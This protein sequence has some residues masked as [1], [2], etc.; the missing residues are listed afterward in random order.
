MLHPLHLLTDFNPRPPRGGRPALRRRSRYLNSYFNPRPPRGGRHFALNVG[1]ITGEFQST[2]S[3]RRT[4]VAL[5][6]YL[7]NTNISIHVLRE[8][9]DI[10]PCPLWQASCRFQST[11]S[12]RRTTLF[13]GWQ[14]IWRS[15]SIHVLR[16]EDD[17]SYF[18]FFLSPFLFQSTSSAR[19]TT[20][21]RL[22]FSI[23]QHYFNPCPPR[24]GRQPPH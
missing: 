17:D 24:G 10:L 3:A 5:Q 4:T 9:D 16:E 15:I 18:H 12:A 23:L 13:R 6:R 1:K 2:S 20:S 14:Y 21:P 19:R 22:V 11:S 7:H 8:E